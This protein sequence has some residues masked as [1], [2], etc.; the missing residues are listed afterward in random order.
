MIL[1]VG[2]ERFT[3]QRNSLLRFPTTRQLISNSIIY[4]ISE[5]RYGFKIKF[6]FLLLPLNFSQMEN[7]F[8]SFYK[9]HIFVC[10][11]QLQKGFEEELSIFGAFYDQ[12]TEDGQGFVGLG[13]MKYNSNINIL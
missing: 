12:P 9:F 7:L 8:V 3:A 5:S 2:G 1:D 4:H 11:A 13:Y 10:L 6:D